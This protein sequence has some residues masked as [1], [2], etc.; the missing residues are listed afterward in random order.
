M[1]LEYAK[2]KNWNQHP[3]MLM[4]INDR[5]TPLLENISLENKEGYIM[6]DFNIN[7]MNYATDNLTSLFLDKACSNRLFLY[8][9]IPR[10][11]TPRSNTIVDNILYNGININTVSGSITTDISDH[12]G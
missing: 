12:L 8:I 1:T 2:Q 3:K 5:L 4:H 11:H 9:N 10:R 6:G 7:L